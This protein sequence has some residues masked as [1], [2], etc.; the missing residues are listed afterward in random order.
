MKTLYGITEAAV[1]LGMNPARLKRWCDYGYYDPDYCVVL[2]KKTYRLFSNTDL[3]NLE[4]ALGRV[5]KVTPLRDV[6]H[7]VFTAD[8]FRVEGDTIYIGDNV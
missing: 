4:V 1:A 5:G 3:E 2:G 8:E 7:T 6:F